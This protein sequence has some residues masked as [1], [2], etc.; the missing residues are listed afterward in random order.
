MSIKKL[1]RGIRNNNPGNIDHNPANKWQ[2][3]LPHD[4]AIEPR[5]SRFVSPEFGIRALAKILLNYQNKHGLN[6]VRKIINRWAP[7]VENDTGAYAEQVAKACGV[8]PDAVISVG[9]LLPL[10]VPA[11]IKHENGQQ[12]YTA[13]QVSAGIQMALGFERR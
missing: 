11:I 3:E 13:E 6:T 4:K 9:Q 1:P 2:G 10:I 5:F 7:P 12:P 8:S